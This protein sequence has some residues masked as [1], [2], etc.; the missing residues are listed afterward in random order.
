MPWRLSKGVPNLLIPAPEAPQTASSRNKFVLGLRADTQQR[1]PLTAQSAARGIALM[2]RNKRKISK[3]EF[4]LILN[5]RDVVLTVRRCDHTHRL[6]QS[7]ENQG[8]PG[9]NPKE[10]ATD[11]LA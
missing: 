10:E 11:E 6:Q 3:I 1:I 7:I 9:Q 2:H 5:R 4:L 8:V